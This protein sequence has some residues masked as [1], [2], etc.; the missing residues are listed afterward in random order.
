MIKTTKGCFIPEFWAG[1]KVIR[2]SW[3]GAHGCWLAKVVNNVVKEGE[4]WWVCH[5]CDRFFRAEAISSSILHLKR[6]HYD[7]INRDRQS[8]DSRP[9]KKQKT[10][11]FPSNT[12]D[13]SILL[14]HQLSHKER[15]LNFIVAGN[16]PF[17]IVELDEFRDLLT[18]FNAEL[19]AELLP[20]SHN[21][22]RNHLESQFADQKEAL[23]QRLSSSPYKK[24]LSF[25]IWTS[26]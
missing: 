4:Y 24:H 8:E 21:T 17:S 5:Y 18:G 16:L 25:D 14:P 1:K 13:R 9:K 22:I 7:A 11:Q 26:P 23:R 20:H 15:L 2:K 3:I 6:E 10:L 19:T 12:G